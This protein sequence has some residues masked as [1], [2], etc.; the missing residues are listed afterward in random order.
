MTHCSKLFPQS[1][2]AVGDVSVSVNVRGD[3][4]EMGVGGVW[5]GIWTARGSRS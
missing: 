3:G 2:L 1:A 4:D 5:G